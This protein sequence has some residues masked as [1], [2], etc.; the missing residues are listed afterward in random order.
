MCSA[1]NTDQEQGT[2]VL[3]PNKDSGWEKSI[4]AKSYM[5]NR[6]QNHWEGYW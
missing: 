2:E 3:K 1:V 4:S 5:Q 6:S